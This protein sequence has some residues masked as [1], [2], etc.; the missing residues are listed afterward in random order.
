MAEY[1][2][3]T[4]EICREF[5]SILKDRLLTGEKI[6]QSYALDETPFMKESIPEAVALP[7]TS[8]EVSRLMKICNRNHIPV[9]ARG[10]GTGL[11]GA[12]VAV[13]GGLLISMEKMNH[14][15]EIDGE[16]MLVRLESGVQLGQLQSACEER[17]LFYPPDPAEKLATLGGNVSTNAGGMR[18]VRYGTTRDYVLGAAVVLP[19]GDILSLGAET[20]KNNSSNHLLPLFLGSEGI[21]GIITELILRVRPL[22]KENMSVLGA[23]SSPEQA[24][25]AVPGLR[26]LFSPRSLEY[27]EADLVLEAQKLNGQHIFPEEAEGTPVRAFLLVTFDGNSPEELL[28]VLEE[29]G[30]QLLENGALD[31]LVGDNQNAVKNIFSV[32][33]SLLD[34]VK[35]LHLF[36]EE[37]DVALP[38]T[39]MSGYL[40]EVT[41]CCAGFGL[42]LRTFGH[43]GDGNLHLYFCGDSCSREEFEIRAEQLLDE[44][45]AKAAARRG[46]LSGE[47]GTGF[48]KRK[49]MKL[50]SD[51][52]ELQIL[53]NIKKTLDPN[54]ILNPQKMLWT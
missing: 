43:A 12:A 5:K 25:K 31:V 17:G 6:S 8:E 42:R 30:E 34:V 36:V 26:R 14:I 46:V 47:H 19:D 23:F 49:Y 20:I 48:V 41:E 16:N 54:L 39:E 53:N 4:A 27:M 24:L 21:F 33:D 45:Y 15:L 28:A 35:K 7:E 51:P 50:F 22:P 32:R 13:T 3:I 2:N 44:I 11:T 38:V 40:D 9:T 18:A 1:G 52:K 37:A 29:A 10:G